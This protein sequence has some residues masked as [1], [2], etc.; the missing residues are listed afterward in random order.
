MLN[1]L[2]GL[3]FA[4]TQLE[5]FPVDTVLEIG[6]GFGSLGEVLLS[7]PRNG[8]FY[9][10]IDIPPTAVYATYYLSQLLGSSRV[11]DYAAVRDESELDLG[12]LREN[13]DAAVLPSWL[14]PR[15]I[16]SVDLFVNFISFQE[17]EPDVVEGYLRQVAR[18][19]ARHVLLRN[20]AEGREIAHTDDQ[21]GVR[22]PTRSE[23]YDRFLPDYE[24]LAANVIP[25]GYRTVDGY[26]SELRL[27][28]RHG[29]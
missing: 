7:D 5:D 1:Y 18:L 8:T 27:Y 12:V 28:R 3:N 25:F 29:V 15:I 6:G 23:D 17:M 16:G 14:L 26:H 13:G 11:I 20:I 4:K 24:L 10:N 22:E 2:L 19:Q 21:L 9:V